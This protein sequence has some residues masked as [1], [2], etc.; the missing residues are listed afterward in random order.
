MDSVF[1]SP[2][3]SLS[4]LYAMGYVRESKEIQLRRTM[5]R[6][7]MAFRVADRVG[8]EPIGVPI[9]SRPEGDRLRENVGENLLT[10]PLGVE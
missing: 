1:R 4:L 10:V 3:P 9:G 8:Q 6:Q 2:V 5:R 7:V